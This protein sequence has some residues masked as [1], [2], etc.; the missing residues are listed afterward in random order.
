MSNGL[1]RLSM[2]QPP[3]YSWIGVF[4][5]FRNQKEAWNI[6][7]NTQDIDRFPIQDQ[8]K[9]FMATEIGSACCQ[10]Y[11][12]CGEQYNKDISFNDDGTIRSSRLRFMHVPLRGSDDYIKAA[13]SA[14]QIV[15]NIT[16]TFTHSL[17]N[18]KAFPYSLFYIYY[19]QYTYIRSIAVENLLLA[20]AVVFLA[21][22][23]IQ[24]LKL[25]I[26]I[27]L[28]VLITTFNLIGMVYLD[29]LLFKDHGFII[30]INAISVVNLITC[31]GLAVEFTAHVA[32]SYF[33]EVGNRDKRLE[34]TLRETG[35]SV[36]IGIG[37]TKFVGVVVLAFAKSTLFRL[38]YFRMYLG[39]VLMGVFHGLVL[40]PTA[41]YWT[42]PAKQFIP[43]AKFD[44]EIEEDSEAAQYRK[45]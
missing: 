38:Y 16:K 11:G 33:K 43:N 8:L 15:E 34:N 1:S 41:L 19:D 29:N 3:V 5:H 21:V 12:I 13:Q 35:S 32:I 28:I 36:F 44:Y 40:L 27:T 6:D 9:K 42:T 39:I 20:L 22:V 10:T 23:L 2:V 17:G 37:L 30:E 26:I 4:N 18:A 31:V 7:C 25:A 45:V 24:N 14:R